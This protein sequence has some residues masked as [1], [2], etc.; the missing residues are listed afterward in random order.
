MLL[1]M[2][3]FRKLQKKPTLFLATTGIRLYRFE[4]LLPEF[5]NAYLALIV[6]GTPGLLVNR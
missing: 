4:Q 6:T 5:E 3:L 1:P 2:G